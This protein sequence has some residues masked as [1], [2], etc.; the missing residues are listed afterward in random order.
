MTAENRQLQLQLQERS[1][2]QSRQRQYSQ[3]VIN[4]AKLFNM[5][6]E[7]AYKNNQRA[8][9]VRQENEEKQQIFEL[10]EMKGLLHQTFR[11]NTEMLT[12]IQS[13]MQN[14]EFEN[15]VLSRLSALDRKVNKVQHSIEV[16]KALIQ[17][18]GER[19]ENLKELSTNGFN[20][21]REGINGLKHDI[22]DPKNKGGFTIKKMKEIL[23]KIVGLLFMLIK[24]IIIIYCESYMWLTTFVKTTVGPVPVIG[25]MLYLLILGLITL[26][27]YMITVTTVFAAPANLLLP[28]KTLDIINKEGGLSAYGLLY[29]ILVFQH[30]VLFIIK[31]I[32]YAISLFSNQFGAIKKAVVDGPLARDVLMYS[33]PVIGYLSTTAVSIKDWFF[34]EVANKSYEAISN[35]GTNMMDGISSTA[36]STVETVGHYSGMSWAY[37]KYMTFS[38]ANVKIDGIINEVS[39]GTTRSKNKTR[40][41]YKNRKGGKTPS[42]SKVLTR[43]NKSNYME[44][45]KIEIDLNNEQNIMMKTAKQIEMEAIN[46][47]DNADISKTGVNKQFLI[48]YLTCVESVVNVS[49][50]TIYYILNILSSLQRQ[51]EKQIGC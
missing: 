47:I 33:K 2:E 39:G 42:T 10:L 29:G 28:Q 32:V 44:L 48:E 22:F 25:Q 31:L 26:A 12:H 3:D 16:N 40:R 7:Q 14:G 17:K 5:P 30:V 38:S 41:R 15:E 34:T 24:L 50:T 18:N 13:N 51:S 11:D 46:N 19:L 36:S 1:E 37:N 27:Y 21:L 20:N 23:K 4:R 8:R 6:L 49:E 9:L 35:A 43:K 45:K